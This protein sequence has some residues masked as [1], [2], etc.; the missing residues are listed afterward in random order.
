MARPDGERLPYGR[1][2]EWDASR[3]P[4]KLEFTVHDL[5]HDAAS[6]LISGGASVLFVSSFLRR[7]DATV[8]LRYYSCHFPGD[9]EWTR[10]RSWTSAL[11]VLRTR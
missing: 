3:K 1:W 10:G 4:L 7:K 9:E 11:R 5:R 8:T 6:L 2:K